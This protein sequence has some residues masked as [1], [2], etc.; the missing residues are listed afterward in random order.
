MRKN[1]Q[2]IMNIILNYWKCTCFS[3]ML[4]LMALQ[5]G[6]IICQHSV[7]YLFICLH[8]V[9]LIKIL[10]AETLNKQY[11]L[12]TEHFL[13]L[14]FCVWRSISTVCF[15]TKDWRVLSV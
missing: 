8:S 12:S 13:T 3:L 14:H 4:M 5:R 7:L 11:H 2:S 9:Q 1:K 6:C 15:K 10:C